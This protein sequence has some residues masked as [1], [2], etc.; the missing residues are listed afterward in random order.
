MLK[1]SQVNPL[2]N[3]DLNAMKSR[4][5]CILMNCL[6]VA[7]AMAQATSPNSTAEKPKVPIANGTVIP[8]WEKGAPG[9][10]DR[11]NEPEK[12]ESYWVAN[13]HNP[14]ITVFLPS[15]GT[16]NGTAVLIAPGGG[17]KELGFKG[18]GIE[19]AEYFCKLGVAAFALKYRLGG[20]KTIDGP[21]PYNTNVHARQ[22]G[23]RAMRLIRS[24]A[25]EWGIDPNRIGMMGFSAGG[26]LASMIV[27]DS[28]E[29]NPT[30][31]DMIDRTS[32]KVNFQIQIYPGG[33][34]I[35][36]TIPGDAP[37]AFLLAAID[38]KGPAKTL[39]SLAE[40]YRDAGR[41][42][43]LHLFAQG[44]HAFNMGN[45]SKLVTIKEWTGRMSDWMKDSKLLDRPSQ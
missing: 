9:F 11:R 40:K 10:E 14:S 31:E 27:Y 3:M 17:H 6:F 43:E 16:A 28:N 12:A 45:R 13:I 41:P 32:S 8:L 42:V 4:L 39:L 1:R 38:D 36:E 44:G 26:Q 33:G 29:G 37:P 18:E 7:T 24:H 15:P 35:P 19:P 22:D 21:K 30:S 25:T 5:L 34:Y 20:D 2:A 23:H